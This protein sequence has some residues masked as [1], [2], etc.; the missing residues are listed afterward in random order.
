MNR[1][2]EKILTDGL[3]TGYAGGASQ[4]INRGS[5]SGQE[6]HIESSKS[7]YHD[8][9]FVDTRLGGGQ[10][11]VIVNEQKFTRLY[12]GGTPE[13]EVLKYLGITIDDVSNYLKTKIL[14]LGDKTRL[15]EDCT[16][17]S[18]N[19]WKYTYRVATNDKAIE[20]TTG[21]ETIDYK[22]TP[23]HMHAFILCPII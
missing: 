17:E 13:P 15:F 4:N 5:F 19:D 8:E 9:W 3:L 20:L 21:M 18:D 11:L 6:S 23:V 16:P 1:K 12:A 2:I 7:V 22:K 10:E 14:Q